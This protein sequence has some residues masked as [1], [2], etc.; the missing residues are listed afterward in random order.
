MVV[1]PAR[2]DSEVLGL[3]T[4]RELR[5]VTLQVIIATDGAIIAHNQ[6][7]L[8]FRPSEPLDGALVPGDTLQ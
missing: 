2:V 5:E 4:Q 3:A 1:E 8:V 7:L 6:Q